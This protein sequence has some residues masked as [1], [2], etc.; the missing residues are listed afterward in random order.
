[1]YL[2]V[3]QGVIGARTAYI[4]MVRPSEKKHTIA[5]QLKVLAALELDPQQTVGL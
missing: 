4:T 5:R 2:S 1:M 3:T